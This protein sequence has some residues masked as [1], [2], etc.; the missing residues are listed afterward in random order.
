MFDYVFCK[1]K[2]INEEDITKEFIQKNENLKKEEESKI[3]AE[4]F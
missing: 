2:S 3:N 4:H 1:E